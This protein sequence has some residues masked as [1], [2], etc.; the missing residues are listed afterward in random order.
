MEEDSVAVDLP[1]LD[2]QYVIILTVLC[3][4]CLGLFGR[5][6]TATVFSDFF[7]FKV[8]FPLSSC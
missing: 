2:A 5:R 7:F 1:N 4:H 8:V 3:F 6:F